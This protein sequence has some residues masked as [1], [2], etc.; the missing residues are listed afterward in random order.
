[1]DHSQNIDKKRSVLGLRKI[2]TAPLTNQ[3]EVMEHVSKS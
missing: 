2:T 3:L 1:M